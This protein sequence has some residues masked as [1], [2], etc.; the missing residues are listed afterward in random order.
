MLILIVFILFILMFLLPFVPGI[1]ELIRKQDAKPLFISMTYVRN[2][3]Y[4]GRSFKSLLHR[5]TAGFT[6]GPGLREVQLSKIE[7]VELTQ[8]LDVFENREVNHML[9]VIGS[10]SSG[11]HS[12]FNKEVYVTGNTTIGPNNIIQ[13]IAGD[14]N[15]SVAAGVHVRRWLDAD[16]DIDIS[17]NCNLGISASSGSKLSLANNCVFRRLYGMPIITGHNR[18]PATIS[19]EKLLPLK[20]SLLPEI[21]FIRIKD[22]TL[23]PETAINKNI[24]FPQSVKIGHNSTLRGNVKSYGI[25]TLEDNVTIDGNVFADGDIFIGRNVKISGNIFSQKSIYISGQTVISRPDKIKSIIG[26]KSI[27]IEQNVIIYGYVATEGYGTVV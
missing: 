2:P 13:A 4:F 7:K 19:P 23:L 16:G 24:V 9:Y 14:G 25:L 3:R 27:R 20:D 12:Q 15:V 18:M 6:L 5:A 11:N 1:I 17:S 21:S 10:L 8:S 22:S 26:K